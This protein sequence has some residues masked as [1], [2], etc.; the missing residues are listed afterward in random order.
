MSE[1]LVNLLGLGFIVFIV[2]W[3]WVVK[4]KSKKVMGDT[5]DIIVEN[6]SY[7]PARIEVA[8]GKKTTL[9][10]LRKDANPCAEKV[11]FDQLNI[12]AD[13]PLNQKVDVVVSPPQAGE[14]DFVCQMQMYR[15]S[16]VAK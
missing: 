10:F 6:G 12:S 5:V 15:G 2:W 9:R 16:L 14:Y 3:F 11:I 7:T 8:V 13:L 4:P 1:V